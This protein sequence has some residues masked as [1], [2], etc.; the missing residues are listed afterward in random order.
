MNF[1]HSKKAL[2]NYLNENPFALTSLFDLLDGNKKILEDS[3]YII[4]MIQLQGLI[5]AILQT[6]AGLI[7]ETTIHVN[8]VSDEYFLL[9][10][11]GFSFDGA[12]ILFYPCN[13]LEVA[14]NP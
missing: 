13:Y 1:A 9:A 2:A 3:S 7:L 6:G 10:V 5:A 4:H 14:E 8:K 12:Q 11:L